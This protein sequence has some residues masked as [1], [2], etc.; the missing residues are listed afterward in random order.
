MDIQSMW[1]N[2][3]N[4]DMDNERALLASLCCLD[5]SPF[6]SNLDVI[7]LLLWRPHR[8]LPIT[9]FMATNMSKV[10]VQHGF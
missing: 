5:Q 7:Q 2:A 9:P 4:V 3:H 10:A 6:V 1:P 8:I